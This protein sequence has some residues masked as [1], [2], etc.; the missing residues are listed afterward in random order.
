MSLRRNVLMLALSAGL[1]AC[2]PYK[3]FNGDY[4]LGPVDPG[5]P[6]NATTGPGKA[7]NPFPNDYVGVGFTPAQSNGT[8]EPVPATVS[9]GSS[10]LYFPFH[11]SAQFDPIHWADWAALTGAGGPSNPLRLRTQTVDATGAPVDK[12]R[13]RAYMFDI[14]PGA[15]DGKTNTSKCNPPSATYVYDQKNDAFPFNQQ[16]N[17]FQQKQTSTDP[18]SLPSDQPSYQPIY[19]EV[20]V[21]SLTYNCESIHS[22]DGVIDGI[23]TSTMLNTNPA[24]PGNPF[25]H[26]VGAPDG[27]YLALAI[28]DPSADVLTTY[29]PGLLDGAPTCP[30]AQS[31]AAGACHNPITH[32]GNQRWGFFDHFLVAYLDGGYVQTRTSMVPATGSNPAQTITQALPML[33][34]TPDKFND[35]INGPSTCNNTAS[36]PGMEDPASCVGHGFDLIEGVGEDFMAMPMVLKPGVRGAT[37]MGYSPICHVLSYDPDKNPAGVATTPQQVSQAALDPDPNAYIYCLQ[38]VN[39]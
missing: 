15:E 22:A 11:V 26:A 27:N 38:V 14:T 1:P 3:N 21:T 13:Q 16:L 30:S 24:P 23:G 33:L 20:P 18:A 10:V 29:D 39:Q 12:D 7:C 25:Y 35:P 32:L 37:G 28:I 19:A 5:C 9:N 36:T 2:N 31:D 4:Y 8:V 17:I 34:F 6:A